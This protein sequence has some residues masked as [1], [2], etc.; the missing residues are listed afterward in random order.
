MGSDTRP[1]SRRTGLTARPTLWVCVV[2]TLMSAPAVTTS[3]ASFTRSPSSDARA[4]TRFDDEV[5]I[6]SLQDRR[7]SVRLLIPFLESTQ[8]ETRARACLAIG[9][10]AS[11]APTAAEAAA[12]HG[13]LAECLRGD[14]AVPVRRAAALALGLTASEQAAA[15][16][17]TVLLPAAEGDPG[18]REAAAEGLGRCGPDAH[19]VAMAAALADPE[20][21][22]VCAALLAVWKGTRTSFLP[23]ILA[24]SA[25]ADPQIRWRAAYA[26][27]RMLGAPPAGRTPLPQG[28]RLTPAERD[29][30]LT[31][32]LPLAEDP[33]LRVQLQALRA[34][35]SPADSA[36]LWIAANEALRAGL[37]HPDVRARIEALRSLASLL[38]GT[39][40]WSA[41]ASALRDPHPHVRITA[42]QAAARILKGPALLEVLTP[43]L[44]SPSPWE[45]ATALQIAIDTL[46]R[47]GFPSQALQLVERA[48]DDA[49]WTVRYA[50]AAALAELWAAPGTGARN[51]AAAAGVLSAPDSAALRA[52]TDS[53]LEGFL[54]DEPR[55]AK[56]VVTPWVL[57]RARRASDPT[58]LLDD[59]RPLLD[60][61]D[62]ILRALAVDGL[63]EHVS[64]IDSVAALGARPGLLAL[65]ERLAQ[66]RSP[67]VRASTCGLLA[68]LVERTRSVDAAELLVQIARRDSARG[69][70]V[71]AIDALRAVTRP[72][73]PWSVE[74]EPLTPGVSETGWSLADYRRA[75]QT[76]HLAQEAI[77]ETESGELHLQL[78]GAMAPL[79]VY[80]FVKLAESGFFDQGAWHRV[81]PDFVVQDGCPRGDGWGGPGYTIRCEINTLHY[82]AGAL[83]MALSGKDTGG[84]Q[85]FLALSDQP[86]LDGRY[87]IFGQLSSRRDAMLAIRQG[88]GIRRVRIV[89]AEPPPE[90]R[91]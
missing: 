41:F 60:H 29:T 63:S 42:I 62:G 4:H 81:V 52:R 91:P 3:A 46:G 64:G 35:G 50:A 22:V 36:D 65:A 75:L 14:P 30:I 11:P 20:P 78:L 7:E 5:K 87:T 23:Q 67:D 70:R 2:M 31:H 18:V 9:R 26:L 8:P 38:A 25:H 79:T 24:L 39:G 13:A 12:A 71:G 68:R 45:R 80:N 61:E 83:G 40:S 34:L 66:D 16:L 73:D 47:G 37:E 19:P 53:L 49:D 51:D 1:K 43:V 28:P 6:L 90:H 88:E 33:D 17:A 54:D 57:S 82:E 76:A 32:L 74:V 69:V 56:A 89:Y 27:M 77:I 58:E 44:E 21:R 84:S 72:T 86:H 59:L 48:R 85:F 10:V 55:V 15:T